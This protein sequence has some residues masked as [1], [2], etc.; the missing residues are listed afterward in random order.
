MANS[1]NL[2]SAERVIPAEPQ[3]IF[4][5]L[6]DPAQHSVIDGSGTVKA[7]KGESERLTL[8]ATFGMSM[9]NKVPYST[10]PKVVEFEEGRK[11]AWQNTG[12]PIW[13]YE[14]FPAD[15]GA[16]VVETYDLTAARGA[17]LLKR[18]GLPKRTRVNMERTLERLEQIVTSSPAS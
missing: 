14:L 15:G 13:R 17:F 3:V 9:K 2:V 8:G 18:I 16:R 7:A 12:G 10:K 6:A 5:I 4:D 11:V 1:T